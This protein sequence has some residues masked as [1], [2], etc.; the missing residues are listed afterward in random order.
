MVK[1]AKTK[2][3]RIRRISARILFGAGSVEVVAVGVE[4]EVVAAVVFAVAEGET[5]AGVFDEDARFEGGV[6]GGG[7]GVSGDV[8][9]G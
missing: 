6:E 7:S 2:T 9:A 8:G 4:V 1:Q 5:E 3:P